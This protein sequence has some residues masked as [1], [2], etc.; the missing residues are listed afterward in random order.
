MYIVY[1]YVYIECCIGC[2]IKYETL[3]V[4]KNTGNVKAEKRL[5]VYK[6]TMFQGNGEKRK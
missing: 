3:G 4:G 5:L 6:S 1:V 2:H